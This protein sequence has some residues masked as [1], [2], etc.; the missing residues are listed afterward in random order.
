MVAAT[1]ARI[2]W[3]ELPAAVR[4]AVEEIVGGT[5]IAAESQPGGFSPGVAA[6]LRTE[7]GRRAFVKAVS[8]DQNDETPG[9][10]RREA[11][12]SAAL[13]PEAPAP[14]LLGS[15]DDGHWIALVLEDVDGRHP[16]TPWTHDEL[17]AVMR[18]LDEFARSG[19]PC[20]VPDLPKASAAL[21][22][23]F[24]GWDR[25]AADPPAD[26]DPWVAVNLDR[27][28]E[29]S[30]RGLAAMDGDTLVH[31]DIRA[32]NLLMGRDDKVHIVDWPW[33]CTGAPWLDRVLLL[34]NV[35]LYGGHDTEALLHASG[36]DVP[37][38][39][40]VLIGLAGF[41]IDKSR[42]PDPQ[43]LPTVRAFQR[44]QGDALIRWLARAAGS[45]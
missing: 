30:R 26:L 28:R 9:L 37:D 36:P 21:A 34:I 16:Q 3:D 38:M 4:Q 43:G 40:A 39:R 44:A 1:G 42:K 2:G 5:V 41:F 15:Y 32:D 25:V 35:E 10:H 29:Q 17:E 7:N 13:P 22:N 8:P 33:A 24:G 27:L 6:R 31:F 12:I 18:T 14:R 11:R 20:P 23:D 19:T 45:R